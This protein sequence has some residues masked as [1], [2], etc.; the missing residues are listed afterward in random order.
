M[1]QSKH[2]L[3]N[4]IIIVMILLAIMTFLT[5]AL[6]SFQVAKL[7]NDF[8]EDLYLSRLSELLIYFIPGMIF[9]VFILSYFISKRFTEPVNELLL[10]T[11]KLSDGDFTEKAEVSN[12][13]EFK[14]LARAFND[15]ANSLET[16]NRF[17]EERVESRTLEL[18]DKNVQLE[19]TMEELEQER[20]KQLSQAYQ[21]G[22]AENA[23]SILHNIGN[24]ITPLKIQAHEALN[25]SSRTSIFMYLCKIHQSLTDQLEKGNLNSFMKDDPKGQQMLPFL[26]KIAVE[27]DQENK[28]HVELFQGIDQQLQYIG[29]IITLQRKY[30]NMEGLQEEFRIEVIVQDA[31]EMMESTLQKHGIEIEVSNELDLPSLYGDSNK[32]AQVLLNL[33]KNAVESIDAQREFETRNG[34]SF[35]GKVEL[36]V[37]LAEDKDVSVVLVDNGIGAE[38]DI[39]ERAFEFGYST[40]ERGSGFGLHDCA[41]F[42]HANGGKINFKSSGKGNGATLKFNLPSIEKIKKMTI[43]LKK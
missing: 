33:L 43:G 13:S 3:K 38:P 17:L 39:L 14:T 8:Q 29:E 16:Y 35:K 4:E 15:M 24:A 2:S 28:K 7:S 36:S 26:Y 5:G 27:L 22:V 10:Y 9:V 30:A 6:L 34:R 20:Q 31:L 19:Q 32:L 23:I 21:S 11:K 37:G 18:Q 40:K 42:I 25:D 1:L 41:N 12:F